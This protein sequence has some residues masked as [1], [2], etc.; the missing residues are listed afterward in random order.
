[1]FLKYK[2][3]Q[4]MCIA[5]GGK[6]LVITNHSP[7][8]PPKQSRFPYTLFSDMVGAGVVSLFSDPD[9]LYLT[10]KQLACTVLNQCSHKL[11]IRLFSPHPRFPRRQIIITNHTS[12][13]IRDSFAFFPLIPMRSKIVVVQHN[14]NGFISYISK[15]FWG[16]WTIDKD[17]K[18]PSG[19]KRL[20][21]ELQKIVEYM[22]SEE[23]L[24][25]VIYPQGRV[26]K[27]TEDCRTVSKMY[28]GAFYMSLMTRYPITT[29]I[30]DY[31]RDG[32]FSMV[33]KEPVDIYQEYKSRMNDLPDVGSFRSDVRNK[34]LL[35]EICERFRN[36]YQEEY[37][38]ITKT[39]TW[40]NKL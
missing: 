19:K 17:D 38:F 5:D 13:A 7:L 39:E 35:D 2:P 20:N 30:N 25:V 18:T 8:T 28:P 24:T 21:D 29:L 15:N 26:P 10:T 14:F 1:M 22:K 6:K 31:S 33:V 40:M 16:A 23:D 32:V 27:S 36:V 12:S 3:E 11:C 4:K 37:E 34:E 9:P